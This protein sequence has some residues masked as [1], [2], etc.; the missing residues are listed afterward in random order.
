MSHHA[1]REP[2]DPLEI[3]VDWIVVGSGAGGASAAVALARGGARVAVVEAGAW[4]DPEHY[5]SSAYGG[6]RDLM[7]AFGGLATAG[8]AQWP[9]VQGEAVGGTT[10]INSAICVRTPGDVF[11]RWAAEH[12]VGGGPMAERIGAIQ[13]AL[14]VELHASRATGRAVGRSDVLALRGAAALGYDSHPTRRFVED[15]A[16]SGQCLQGCRAGRKQS[17]NLNF[18]PETLERGGV[19]LS[20]APVAR[21]VLEGNRAAGVRG[22]FRH[23]RTRRAGAS[24]QVRARHGVFVAAS[25]IQSPLLLRRSGIRNRSL[26]RQFHAHPGT[27]LF[28]WYDDPVDMHIGATQ[29]WSSLAHRDTGGFKLES[30]S[31]PLELVAGRLKGGGAVLAERLEDFRHLAMWV[32]A[33]KAESVGS[34]HPG[35][36]GPLVRYTLD[37]ADMV[38]M[39]TA[40]VLLAQTHFAAGARWVIPGIHGLP[41]KIDA[42]ALHTI[43][44]APLDPRAW[45]AVLSHL[46]GGCPM[47]ADPARSVCDGEGRVHG[48]QGL[49]IADA[50]QIP[51]NLGVNPQHTIMALARLRAETALSRATP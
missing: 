7:P 23:P 18:I 3:E 19:V 28:G 8:R 5:P 32:M 49:W 37:R 27:G 15:C 30:L 50:S 47:G 16:G 20:C 12:G 22:R 31:I 40:A 34:I 36:L 11:V 1:F 43:E 33:V 29:G 46:F 10:V 24:F 13:D 42:D 45:V 17:L 44:D 26:G 41:Y 14:E 51:T 9:V 6:A 25:A 2:G 35:P 48:H 38:K 21:I 39:R 4:R